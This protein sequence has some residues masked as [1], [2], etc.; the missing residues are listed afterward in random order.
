[1][2][3]NALRQ[4]NRIAP[5]ALDKQLYT[6]CGSYLVRYYGDAIRRFS[7]RFDEKSWS[8][9]RHD[10]HIND[11]SRVSEDEPYYRRGTSRDY[12]DNSSSRRRDRY[13]FENS[14]RR[15]DEHD[16]Q[17]R[18]H[19]RPLQPGYQTFKRRTWVP[20]SPVNT[21][22]PVA[23]PDALIRAIRVAFPHVKNPTP[24]QAQ[25]IPAIHRGGDVILMDE[26]GSGK[27]FGS[28][29]ALLSETQRPHLGIT[30]LYV[31]P[32][33]DLAYQIE[34]WCQKLVPEGSTDTLTSPVQVLARPHVDSVLASL[35]KTQPRILIATPGALID[36]MAHPKHPLMLHLS[37]QRI[38]VDEVDVVM[39]IPK[40][41]QEVRLSRRHRPEAVQAIDH[42][43][44][45]IW[46]L[47]R[48]K[49]QM[50]MMSAT[51][52]MHVRKWL[53]AQNGWMAERVVRLDGVKSSRGEDDGFVSGN[54]DRIVHSAVAVGPDGTLR[55]AQ[56]ANDDENPGLE[57]EPGILTHDPALVLAAIPNQGTTPT[58]VY[59]RLS[60]ASHDANHTASHPSTNQSIPP[61]VLEAIATS[62]ALDVTNRAMCVVPAGLSVVP[63]VEAFRKLG[64][65]AR[66]LSLRDEIEHISRPNEEGASTNLTSSAPTSVSA[67]SDGKNNRTPT[68]SSAVTSKDEPSPNPTLLVTNTSSVRGLDIPTL[69]HIY[70]IGGVGSS[71][72][73]RHIAGRVGRFRMPGAVVSF[74]DA[75]GTKNIVGGSTGERRL[76]NFY[77]QIGAKVVPFA[78]IQ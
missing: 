53:F 36:A 57:I 18:H 16:P 37:I 17:E 59:D 69:S 28:V 24:I 8:W 43:L 66:L 5:S 38:I 61:S 13:S 67:A 56:V 64:V 22:T 34:S 41:Y 4:G 2:L 30:T 50:V 6:R 54:N 74:V 19:G 42:I 15:R 60:D 32:H 39:N 68:A 25:L 52:W 46:R 71:A 11:S 27:T 9:D 63:V 21:L 23:D 3:R 73:Y 44:E 55:N 7:P 14:Y 51:L 40:R 49:P 65:E 47:K 77:K 31:V 33:R 35:K 10:K 75:A 76:L 1:M 29:L 12:R 70:I 20:R 72:D 26:T 78:H 58:D 45:D 62:V 48:P